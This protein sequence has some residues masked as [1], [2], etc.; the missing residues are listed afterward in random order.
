MWKLGR[1]DEG[2]DG[3]VEANY[4][5]GSEGEVGDFRMK[6]AKF[7]KGDLMYLNGEDGYRGM[8]RKG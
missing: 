4:E 3:E 6:Q 1:C 5:Q 2:E 7:G 8:T